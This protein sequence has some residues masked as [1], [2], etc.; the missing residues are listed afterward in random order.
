MSRRLRCAIYTRKSTEEG[1]DQAFNSLHAQREAC[2][3]YVLSQTGE[4]W[5]ALKAQY[6]D[7]GFSGGSMSRPGLQ[8]LLIDIRQGLID[9]VVVYKV[10]RLT[11]SLADFAKIVESFD[12]Q[13]VSFVSVTQALNTTTSMGRLTLNVLL[14][15]AQF[16]RE[17]TGERIRDKVAASKAKGLRMGGRPPLG[18]D[19][20]DGRLAINQAEAPTV[21][22]L[23]DLYLEHGSIRRLE[24][25]LRSEGIEAKRWT[26]KAGVEVGGGFMGRGPLHHILCNPAYIGV[27]RHKDKRY[28]DTHP[29]IIN[30]AIWDQVQARLASTNARQ[31]TSPR[32]G[33]RALLDGK[34][35]DDREHPMIPVHTARGAKR[36]R[37]YV[38]RAKMFGKGE[39]G[40]LPRISAGLIE[41]FL[42]D[43]LAPKLASD[44]AADEDRA[45]RVAGAVEKI[46]LGAGS[47]TI[48]LKPGS[49]AGDG[50]PLRLPFHMS[51]GQGGLIIDVPGGA[52]PANPRIDRTLVRAVVLAKA[53]ARDLETGAIA[54]VKVLAKRHHLC[55]RYTARL[56]PLAYLAPDLTAAIIEGRQPRGLTLSLL[57][58]QPLPPDWSDQRRLIQSLIQR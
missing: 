2:E 47:M 3:A 5:S 51:R 14:S 21:R 49:C 18:Y 58:A 36:Y 42:A 56:L 12:A 34:L 40:S 26:T 29:P 30:Q 10:D 53:W 55:L 22:R 38:S 37:Y 57:T 6:D 46:V 24:D 33:E 31:P 4:G 7:G 32:R 15:F 25:A 50:A 20:R 1:L 44:W 52:S 35:F 27:T 17:V 39:P 16:E 54:S 11:R 45:A 43:H 19:I 13:G 23:F 41:S 8:Q 48:E 28:P 9:V